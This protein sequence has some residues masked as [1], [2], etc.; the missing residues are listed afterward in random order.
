MIVAVCALIAAILLVDQFSKFL[1][2]KYIGLNTTCVIIKGAFSITPILNTGGGF[3]IFPNQT[4]LFISISILTIIFII[5]TLLKKRGQCPFLTITKKGAVPF[6]PLV[7]ILA[8]TLGNLV[9]RL[10]L[11]AVIDF[12][13]FKVWPVFNIADSCIT[14]GAFLLAWQLLKP[15]IKD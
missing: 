6:F 8:G 10:R 14:V 4:L 7:M 12:I 11:G 9:D 3:G 1:I 15:R 2:L 13:D 5:Y